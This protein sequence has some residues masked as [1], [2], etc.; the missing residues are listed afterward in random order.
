MIPIAA[1]PRRAAPFSRPRFIRYM[2]I[3][4]CISLYALYPTV[5]DALRGAEPGQ[6][7]PQAQETLAQ[8]LEIEPPTAAP[9]PLSPAQAAQNE[10]TYKTLTQ[11]Q[12]KVA[13]AR[14]E[15]AM[16]LKSVQN[17]AKL[18]QAKHPGM[19]L[20]QALKLA[21]QAGPVV[22]AQAKVALAER[23]YEQAT[24]AAQPQ[25]P[26]QPQVQTTEPPEETPFTVLRFGRPA[27]EIRRQLPL[28][29][30]PWFLRRAGA[31]GA[32]ADSGGKLSIEVVVQGKKIGRYVEWLAPIDADRSKLIIT[33]VPAD[34]A[35]LGDLVASLN[36]AFDPPT[37]MPLVMME[38]TRSA[39]ADEP[40][41]LRVLEGAPNGSGGSFLEKLHSLGMCPPPQT[42]DFPLCDRDRYAANIRHATGAKA[43]PAGGL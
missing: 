25:I 4:A 13:H 21:M 23:E 15:V 19:T 9:R 6:P 43:A 30:L 7:S 16:L 32:F 22:L 14:V 42:D 27:E 5:R 17:Q 11:A 34:A 3:L 2:A 26:A 37:L 28:V 24:L 38:H 40:F 18:D 20:E 41:N 29:G 33:F 10:E 39:L 36:T 8:A 35:L 31:T 1:A 12:M